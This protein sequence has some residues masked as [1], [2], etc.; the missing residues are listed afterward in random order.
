MGSEHFERRYEDKL[1]KINERKGR[2][3]MVMRVETRI[4]NSLNILSECKKTSKGV[5]IFTHNEIICY[6]LQMDVSFKTRLLLPNW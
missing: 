5:V 3:G 1:Q 6:L 2:K 4:I